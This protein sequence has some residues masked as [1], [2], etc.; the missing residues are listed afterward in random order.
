VKLRLKIPLIFLLLAVIFY[1]LI[2]SYISYVQNPGGM[3]S[4]AFLKVFRLFGLLLCTTFLA[5]VVLFQFV[6]STPLNRLI[7]QLNTFN[8]YRDTSFKT[9]NWRKT[10]RRDEIDDLYIGF[11]KM[12]KRLIEAQD[13]QLDMIMAI[14]HDIKTPLTSIRGFMEL[15]L[16]NQEIS[17]INKEDYLRLIWSKTDSIMDLLDELSAYSKNES[18]L[19]NIE[20]I[21]LMLKSLYISIAREYEAELA[22]LGYELKWED[23]LLDN[24]AV[25]ANETMIRR[26]FANIVSNAVRYAGTSNLV[27][28]FKAFSERD[29]LIIRIEDNGVG[30]PEDKLGLIF[31]KFYTSDG[32]RQRAFGGTG[33]GLSI[34]RSIITRFNGEITAY[35]PAGKGLGIEFDLPRAVNNS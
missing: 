2:I 11:E 28:H 7:K 25:M 33:L 18:E 34:C 30:V 24:D 23:Q 12:A 17:D 5:N 20:M 16:S 3:D 21:P 35:R 10:K 27:V 14:T 19:H 22:G 31:H 29:S 15:I 9:Y 32:S 6:V 4:A 1:T 8:L 26:L 13:E